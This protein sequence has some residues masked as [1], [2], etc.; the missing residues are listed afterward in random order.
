MPMI[1]LEHMSW[2]IASFTI[3]PA[4]QLP[5]YIVLNDHK[6]KRVEHNP[7]IHNFHVLVIVFHVTWSNNPSRLLFLGIFSR[8]SP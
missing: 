3:L 1:A 2:G 5:I 7:Q 8:T 4:S 6:S